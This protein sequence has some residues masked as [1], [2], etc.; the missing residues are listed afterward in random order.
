MTKNFS[1]NDR[2]RSRTRRLLEALLNYADGKFDDIH[3]FNIQFSRSTENQIAFNTTLK[4]L[5]LLIAKDKYD[6][7]LNQL[8]II[9]SLHQMQYKLGIIN[10]KPSNIA[11]QNWDFILKL[12]YQDIDKNLENFD[13][14]WN[15]LQDDSEIVELIKQ[16]ESGTVEFKSSA[17]WNLE[18]DKPDKKM[19]E[20][21][22]KTV[23]AFLN[24]EGGTLLIGVANDGKLVGLAQDY[25]VNTKQADRDGYE[26]FLT[27]L[28]F[29]NNFGLDLSAQVKFSFHTIEQKEICQV[30]ISKSPKPVYLT[31]TDKHGHSHEQ[32]WIRTGNSNHKLT[33]SEF[34][35]Y[36]KYRF[37]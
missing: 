19:E 23:A 24:S 5:E 29:L 8:E 35:D 2:T 15:V 33:L 28:L 27:Q 13:L 14:K 6:G 22:L 31:I 25:K 17:R 11:S 3:Q 9:H 7:S 34:Y 20:V 36:C 4:G 30:K 37:E 12:E 32:F 16:G 26:Q 1:D 10:I 18:E 21:I